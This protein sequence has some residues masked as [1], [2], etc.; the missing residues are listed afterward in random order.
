MHPNMKKTSQIHQDTYLA[1]SSEIIG[2]AV[3]LEQGVSIWPQAIL[4]ADVQPISIDKYTNVQD[5]V[6]IHGTHNSQYNPEGFKTTI[7]QY[8]TIGH[9]AMIHGASIGDL[10]LV[11]MSS[12]IL[13]GS[14]IDS[15]T[16]IGAGTLVPPKKHLTAGLWVG[17]PAK[18]VREL[19]EKEREMIKY[20][21]D[22][23]WK[24]AQTYKKEI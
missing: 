15:L 17:S 1:Q 9:K 14:I 10:V 11:G 3:F 2:G 21:A 5:Q 6:M 22:H 8:V 16:I 18:K 24:L 13:D 12:I 4:R 23:Y 19:T 20:S 7:G